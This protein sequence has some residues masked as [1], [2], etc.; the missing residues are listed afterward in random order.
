[1]LF[2]NPG[3]ILTKVNEWYLSAAATIGVSPDYTEHLTHYMQE[4]GFKDIKEIT[5]DIPI[6]EW[7][8]TNC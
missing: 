8:E 2:K 6:G 1:M 5:H 3:P 7:P 4:A